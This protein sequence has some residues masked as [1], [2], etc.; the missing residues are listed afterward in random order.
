MTPTASVGNVTHH[1]NFDFIVLDLKGRIAFNRAIPAE[2]I[3]FT[4]MSYGIL[5]VTYC[6]KGDIVQEEKTTQC[7]L[8]ERLSPIIK[9][10]SLQRKSM[11][12]TISLTIDALEFAVCDACD[13]TDDQ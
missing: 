7:P 13:A 9:S 12:L 11:A 2:H 5:C 3:E 1:A 10:Q 6:A 4:K 8:K